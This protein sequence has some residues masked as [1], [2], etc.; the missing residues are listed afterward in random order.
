MGEA[1][2]RPSGGAKA[3]RR[4]RRRRKA[5]RITIRW[6]STTGKLRS[7]SGSR[8]FSRRSDTSSALFPRRSPSLAW[9][10]V[11]PSW[12]WLCC[13]PRLRRL[14]KRACRNYQSTFGLKIKD[15]AKLNRQ[16]LFEYQDPEGAKVAFYFSATGD[17]FVFSVTDT[18][19]DV[20]SV[21]LPVRPGGV[22][23]ARFVAVTCQVGLATNQTFMRVLLHEREVQARALPFR[24]DWEVGRGREAPGVLTMPDRIMRR[25][26]RLHSLLWGTPR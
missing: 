7:G 5:A 19:G 8:F 25:S 18:R 6:S 12:P 14:Q 15:A 4:R 26:K 1:R 24:M 16:Y 10:V 17:R 2:R 11:S 3:R 21:D 23:I 13:G 9:S 22:P 20:Q